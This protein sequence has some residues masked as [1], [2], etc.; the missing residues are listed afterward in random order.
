[1]KATFILHQSEQSISID[2]NIESI[3]RYFY[4]VF[5]TLLAAVH[6]G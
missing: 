5:Y 1:M 6:R 4:S 3:Q 2:G